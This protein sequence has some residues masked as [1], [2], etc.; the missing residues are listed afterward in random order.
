ME[1]FD[2]LLNDLVCISD[3]KYRFSELLVIISPFMADA[4]QFSG[5]EGKE[6]TKVS[7]WEK[8]L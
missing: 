3:L 2:P 4:F 5:L 8:T 1:R 6:C 7:T